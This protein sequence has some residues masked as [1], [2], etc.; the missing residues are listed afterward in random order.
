MA[1]NEDGVWSKRAASVGFEVPPT[2]YQTWWFPLLCAAPCLLLVWLAARW[3]MR[4][5][6]DEYA[7]RHQAI[8]YERERIARDLHDT[9]LQGIQGL[10]LHIQSAVEVLPP[11]L[12]FRSS[13]EKSLDRAEQML[14]E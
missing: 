13:L 3:R 2:V 14:G 4:R 8:L 7:A 6:H 5:I 12:P 1:A 11:E 9:L 10:I